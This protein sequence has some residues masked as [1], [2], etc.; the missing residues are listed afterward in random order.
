MKTINIPTDFVLVRTRLTWVEA[1]YGFDRGWLNASSMIGLA[2]AALEEKT[3]NDP[4]EVRLAGLR[5]YEEWAVR[6]LVEKLAKRAGASSI[7]AVKKKWLCLILSWVYENREDFDDPF[8]IIDEIYSDFDYPE[9]IK[10]F[11]SYMPDGEPSSTPPYKAE[12]GKER[13]LRLW[14]EYVDSCVAERNKRI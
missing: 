7:E 8:A 14:K 5:D 11:V 9:E 6:E 4:A 13:M 10:G 1:Q 3:E 12:T 2:L